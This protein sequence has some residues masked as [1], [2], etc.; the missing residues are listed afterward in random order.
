MAACGFW[1]VVGRIQP[2]ALRSKGA[3]ATASQGN[4]QRTTPD[5][6]QAVLMRTSGEKKMKVSFFKSVG[7]MRKL[8]RST[9]PTRHRDAITVAFNGIH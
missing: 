5:A 2:V 9:K 4:G 6:A 7:M 8:L 1:G 3:D